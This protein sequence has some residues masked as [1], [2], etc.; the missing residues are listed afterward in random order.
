MISDD[1]VYPPIT[2]DGDQLERLHAQAQVLLVWNV[3]KL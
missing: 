1:P 3:K 2:I